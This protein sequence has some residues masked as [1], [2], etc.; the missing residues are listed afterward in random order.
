MCFP[1]SEVKEEIKKAAEK[2]KVGVPLASAERALLPPMSPINMMRAQMCWTRDH[3]WEHQA[4][5]EFLLLRCV[6]ESTRVGICVKFFNGAQEEC[7]LRK[8]NLVVEEFCEQAEKKGVVTN[9]VG[10]LDDFGAGIVPA[11][12]PEDFEIDPPTDSEDAGAEVSGGLPEFAGESKRHEVN[13]AVA[14]AEGHAGL[15][16]RAAARGGTR[17]SPLGLAL[18]LP[19]AP[20]AL[21]QEAKA[22]ATRQPCHLAKRGSDWDLEDPSVEELIKEHG[23]QATDREKADRLLAALGGGSQEGEALATLQ[24]PCPHWKESPGN[25]GSWWRMLPARRIMAKGASA[26]PRQP[27]ALCASGH[28]YPVIGTDPLERDAVQLPPRFLEPR[29]GA[30][31]AVLSREGRAARPRA[32]DVHLDDAAVGQR[33]KKGGSAHMPG[34]QSGQKEFQIEAGVDATLGRGA[35]PKQGRLRDIKLSDGWTPYAG[36]VT[37][38]AAFGVFVDFGCERPGLLPARGGQRGGSPGALEGLQPGDEVTVY[39]ASRQRDTGKINLSLERRQLPRLRWDSVVADGR[40]PYCGTVA[41]VTPFGAFVDLG[42]ELQGLM[43]LKTLESAQLPVPASGDEV[44]VYVYEK[45]RGSGKLIPGAPFFIYRSQGG[46]GRTSRPT[47][48]LRTRA[49]C[50]S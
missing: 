22:A 36:R 46:G 18:P 4:C 41:N 35:D 15:L 21:D 7:T 25:F 19:P 1:A 16:Q 37:S 20:L 9:V 11:T 49:S 13:P 38:R 27:R 42:T 10:D 12:I 29:T 31:C 5:L 2:A 48:R 28:L 30:P 44:T 26:R 47:G 34:L 43:P 33:G 24:A 8:D 32:N 50:C 23:V 14:S 45:R 17:R 39:V 6:K 3:V 40:T